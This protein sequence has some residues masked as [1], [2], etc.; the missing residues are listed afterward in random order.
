MRP[1][2]LKNTKLGPEAKIQAALIRRLMG[3]GWFCKE[4]HGN[5]F[6][7]GFPDVF[8]CHLSYG[9][10]WI[11]VKQPTGFKIKD[12]QHETFHEF[13]KRNIGVW[14]LTA[15]TQWE[16]NKLLAPDN[17]YTFLTAFQ[18]HNRA[19]K[20]IEKPKE[21]KKQP[22]GPERQI[23]D[24]IKATLEERGW[25]C[26]DTH[27]NIFQ[28]GFPD[29]YVC[30]KMYGARWIE[31]KNPKGYQFTPAQLKTFPMMQ[32]HGCGVWV[33]TDSRWETLEKLLF[34]PSNWWR[35]LDAFKS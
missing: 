17:W 3:D 26:K 29:L 11:E 15:D 6:Q 27:G 21:S 7:S 20:P 32:A 35:Y 10:R 28:Y 9:S 22:D 18:T 2:A 16:V 25:Y 23:Q 31:V 19:S 5:E 4:T 34:S 30:H 14:I 12:S 8:A 13:S 33:A 24:A 1:I